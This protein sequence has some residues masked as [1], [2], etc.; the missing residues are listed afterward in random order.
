MDKMIDRRI[1][2]LCRRRAVTLEL[3]EFLLQTYETRAA[4]ANEGAEE[5]ERLTVENLVELQLAEGLT[6]ADIAR[7]EPRI[8]GLTAAVSHWLAAID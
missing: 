2:R 3:P 4:E 6:L 5:E 8:P 7:L 1:Q